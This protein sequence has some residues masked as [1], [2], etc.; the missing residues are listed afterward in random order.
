MA[1]FAGFQTSKI[2]DEQFSF[3]KRAAQRPP[4][5]KPAGLVFPVLKSFWQIQNFLR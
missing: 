2:C 3:E 1:D 4:L 5:L